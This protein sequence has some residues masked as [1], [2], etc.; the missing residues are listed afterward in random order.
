MTLQEWEEY[1]ARAQIKQ[2]QSVSTPHGKILLGERIAVDTSGS[3]TQPFFE[4]FWAIERT[5]CSFAQCVRNDIWVDDGIL[6]R[7]SERHERVNDAMDAA[8]LWI[9]CNVKAGAYA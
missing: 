4:T 2:L 9:A 6:P 5:D 3:Y 7:R 8:N 1:C